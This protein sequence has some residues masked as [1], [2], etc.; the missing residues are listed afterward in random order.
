MLKLLGDTRLII[1]TI[2][3]RAPVYSDALGYEIKILIN[4]QIHW[5][6]WR[7]VFYFSSGKFYLKCSP[8]VKGF[9]RKLTLMAS[10]SQQHPL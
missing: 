3:A 7:D 8:S 1:R 6:L 5:V 2:V 9:L 4:L 10:L